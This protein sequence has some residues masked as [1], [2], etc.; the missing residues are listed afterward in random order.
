MFF[1]YKK[2]YDYNGKVAFKGKGNKKIINEILK[3]DFYS[4]NCPKSLDRQY[5]NK[6]FKKLKLIDRKDSIHTA[7]MITILSIVNC[8]RLNRIKIK[9]IILT[10]GG[11]KNLFLYNSLKKKLLKEK[12]QLTIIDQ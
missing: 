10:G 2:N 7:T 11:R 4:L 1:F 12:I 8:I 3:D 6:Y 9:N 5:F